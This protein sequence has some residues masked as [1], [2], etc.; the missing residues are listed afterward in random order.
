MGSRYST[1][2]HEQVDHTEKHLRERVE[3]GRG[4]RRD[5]GNRGP[6]ARR[7][8][9]RRSLVRQRHRPR[10]IGLRKGRR[11]GPRCVRAT[12]LQDLARRSHRA[13][14]TRRG[15]RSGVGAIVLESNGRRHRSQEGRHARGPNRRATHRLRGGWHQPVRPKEIATHRRGCERTRSRDDLR[16]GWQTRTRHRDRTARVADRAGRRQRRDLG[17]TRELRRDGR[18]GLRRPC[19]PVRSRTR[20]AGP[21]SGF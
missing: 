21:R 11:R 15:H 13:R 19:V 10:R 12:S 16:V 3:K 8:A 20:L 6:R 17:V 18:S 9:V 4:V 14:A 5:S 1:T 7:S 2:T